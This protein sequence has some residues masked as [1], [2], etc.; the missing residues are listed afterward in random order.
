MNVARI[1]TAHVE[2]D[3]TRQM[4]ANIR[5]VS[6]DIAI[7]IDTKGP[8]IRTTEV[9]Q[10]FQVKEGETI[11]FI[12]N[13]NEK[14]T[15]QNIVVNHVGFETEVPVG[16]KIL[17][18]D[19]DIAFEVI[20]I[21]NKGLICKVLN[22]GTI[23]SHKSIN[24]PGVH[25]SL[26]ALSDKDR[27]FI[28]LAIEQDLTF[29]AHSFVRCKEDVMC[30]QE[31]LDAKN[32]KIKIKPAKLSVNIIFRPVYINYFRFCH[33]EPSLR[34]LSYYIVNKLLSSSTRNTSMT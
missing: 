19:G 22:D 26:P 5:E 6:K 32:S 18:D 28:D 10:P 4:I 24:V 20:A 14:T 29:I 21:D 8:E 2:F 9:E 33:K 31:I 15:P 16:T 27:K 12:G 11:Y 13:P 1:N 23:K 25:I 34:I 3:A 30:I 17:I 7:L